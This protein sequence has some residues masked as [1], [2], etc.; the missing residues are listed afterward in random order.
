MN[1]KTTHL[2]GD[3]ALDLFVG[4]PLVLEFRHHDRELL[5]SL[6][7]DK[8]LRDVDRARIEES[9][10]DGPEAKEKKPKRSRGRQD[11]IRLDFSWFE[12]LDKNH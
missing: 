11:D 7:D 4:F 12:T 8:G 2:L 10:F 5:P 6:L 1:L 3:H 9:V